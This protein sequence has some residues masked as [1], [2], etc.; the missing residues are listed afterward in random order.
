MTIFYYG[1]NHE[2]KNPIFHGGKKNND[3]GYGFYTTKSL[4]LASEWASKSSGEESIVN[5]YDIDI[6]N[7]KILDLTEN[8]YSVL[9]WL[10]ILLKNRIFTL[11]NPISINAY[12]YILENFYIDITEFDIVK[13]YR[14]DDSYFSF[15]KDFL[16]NSISLSQ[17]KKAMSLGNLGIQYVFI[18]KKSYEYIKFIESFNID[19]KKYYSNYINRDLKAR[20]KYNSEKID[21]TNKD[22]LFINDIMK[23]GIK[24][25]DSRL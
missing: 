2:I 18:S 14:A 17:L 4:E 11:I 15:A 23:E 22:E 24:N 8:I 25:G 10:A 5:K 13:G 7:L 16:N 19:K 12:N 21:F 3:Y 1:S 6:K 9:N 20:L